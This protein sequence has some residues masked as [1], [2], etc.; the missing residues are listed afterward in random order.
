VSY[1]GARHATLDETSMSQLRTKP[2]PLKKGATIGVVSPAAT[3]DREHLE[4]GVGVLAKL[5]FQVKVSEHALDRFG[6]LAGSD[7]IRA[8]E[9]HRFFDDDDV[10]A[11]FA[12]RGG[13]GSGRILP[14]I[15]FQRLSRQPKIFVGF[16]DLTFLLNAIVE[17]SNLAAFH[18]PMVAM[19]LARGVSASALDQLQRL[20]MG[21]ALEFGAPEVIRAGIAEGEV[22][23]GCLS[24]I[25]AM[26]G[27]R[28]TP[29]FAGKIL[30]IEDTGE[31]AYKIDRMMVQLRQ[32]GVLN[33]VAG[34]VFGTIRPVE[35]SAQ[36][37]QMIS[38]FID[39][40]TRGLGCPVLSRLEAGHGSEHFTNPFGIRARLDSRRGTLAMLESAVSV[41]T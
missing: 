3:V 13:Y 25:V 14:L 20:L 37:R 11:I 41:P 10:R 23:G 30:F 22:I 15:D 39:E 36:E 27:T 4:R 18:G 26:L 31:K 24:V 35:G 32:S 29:S 5:G 17:R 21:E 2:P 28:Y 19:D 16:S 38:H 40:Q 12:A 8:A 34:I 9:I 7:Q 6:I 33:E 1:R